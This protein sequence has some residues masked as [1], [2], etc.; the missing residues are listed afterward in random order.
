MAQLSNKIKEY[1]KANGVSEVDF[2]NDVKLQDDSNGQG[3]YIAEW[4]LDIA[5]PTQ[6]QLDALESQA[7]TYENNQ[8][9]IATR[10]SLYGSWESQLEE[11]Y[12]D[13]IDSWKARILQIKTDNPKE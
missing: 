12:D 6:A 10:K 7:Q 2:L 3:V 5:Q 9:I 13:G 11:I 8:Q 4:N 1:C